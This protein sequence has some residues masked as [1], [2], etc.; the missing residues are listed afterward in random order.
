VIQ[1]TVDETASK[2]LKAKF[3]IEIS[4]SGGGTWCVNVDGTTVSYEEG[5]T[6]GC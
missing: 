3:G 1:Y 5:P 4:G 2:D 6:E